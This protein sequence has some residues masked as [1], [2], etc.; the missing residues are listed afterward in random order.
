[1]L[2]SAQLSAGMKILAPAAH[3]KP[4]ELREPQMALPFTWGS[5]DGTKKSSLKLMRQQEIF[6][7]LHCR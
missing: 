2:C 6:H 3:R 4:R 7:V 1:M 5:S